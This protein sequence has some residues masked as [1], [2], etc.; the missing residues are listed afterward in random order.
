ASATTTT[1]TTTTKNGGLDDDDN[2]KSQSSNSYSSDLLSEISKKMI[3]PMLKEFQQSSKNDI[4]SDDHHHVAELTALFQTKLFPLLE[5][6]GVVLLQQENNDITNNPKQQQQHLLL[7]ATTILCPFLPWYWKQIQKQ[8]RQQQQQQ[9]QRHHEQQST[10]SISKSIWELIYTCLQQGRRSVVHDRG[11]GGGNGRDSRGNG[12]VNDTGGTQSYYSSNTSFGISSLLRRRALYLLDVITNTSNN[13]NNNNNNNI[14]KDYILCAE[15]FEMECERHIIDQLWPVVIKLIRESYKN[16]AAAVNV[17]EDN[18]DMDTNGGNANVTSM[19]LIT[20]KWIE[21]LLGRIVSSEQLAVRKLGI[22]RL[23]QVLGRPISKSTSLTIQDDMASASI[24]A[25]T[26]DDTVIVTVPMDIDESDEPSTLEGVQGQ[27]QEQQLSKKKAKRAKQKEAHH[28]QQQKKK[29]KKKKGGSNEKV[30]LEELSTELLLKSL[31]SD[32][33]LWDV[34]VPAWDSLGGS[35]VGYTMHIENTPTSSGGN[36]STP[37]EKYTRIDMVPLFC[38]TIQNYTILAINNT[39]SDSFFW[40]GLWDY[41]R[42]V[43]HLSAK[44]LISVY[45][46]VTELFDDDDDDEEEKQQQQ[47]QQQVVNI[48]MDDNDLKSIRCT[49]TKLFETFVLTHR[50][51]FLHMLSLMLSK[52]RFRVS[53]SSSTKNKN[54]NPINVLSLFGLFSPSYFP[55]LDSPPTEDDNDDVVEDCWTIEKED[56]LMML[57]TFIRQF[58]RQQQQP[59]SSSS[60]SYAVTVG[61]TLASAF[62]TGQVSLS[63]SSKWTPVEGSSVSDQELGW[64]VALFCT[65]AVV[66]PTDR[67]TTRTNNNNAGELLWPAIHKGLSQSASAVLMG[68]SSNT[69]NN[70]K[71]DTVARGLLLLENGC[72]L[73]QISGLGNGDLVVNPKTQ[74]I[75]PPPPNIE[76]L[77]K[78]G[79]DFIKWHIRVLLETETHAVKE[80]EGGTTTTGINNNNKRFTGTYAYLISQLKVLH[81]SYPSSHA[82]SSV[83]NEL[84]KTSFE[85][86]SQLMAG[87]DASSDVG[88]VKKLLLLGLI[89]GACTCGA[90]PEDKGSYVSF[91][92]LLL[93]TGLSTSGEGQPKVWVKSSRSIIQYARWAAISCILPKI[94]EASSE[95]TSTDPAHA[96]ELDTLIDDLL[97]EGIKGTLNEVQ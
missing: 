52:S 46:S 82:V 13:N 6:E 57:G 41:D 65:L 60:S 53:S 74:Q 84:L 54:W 63:S 50:K 49:F 96:V 88:D 51:Q 73:R 83:M 45:S 27:Q 5:R 78:G 62:V 48:P 81:Q 85:E 12:H 67:P 11:S 66:S 25:A 4:I 58:E 10:I 64:A 72:R 29:Q 36:N 7:I 68:S 91:C 87:N 28:Q 9:G 15:T 61:A 97:E 86:L 1:T 8:Q 75:M 17:S 94:L 56:M 18:N 70:P 93:R 22:F 43:C 34:L 76:L 39:S 59:A 30:T 55:L 21:L 79:I 69:S 71:A 35:S 24:A 89:Y 92:R 32:T 14:W 42:V 26:T 37:T 44:T 31:S 80:D 23:L 3:L 16:N 40:K 33:F 90:E 20:S 77:L 19:P 47:Q 95:S 38:Q 2:G